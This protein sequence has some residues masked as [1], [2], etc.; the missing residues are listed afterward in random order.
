MKLNPG[1]QIFLSLVTRNQLW[2]KCPQVNV[3]LIAHMNNLF[4]TMAVIH[5]GANS[6]VFRDFSGK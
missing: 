4:L 6:Q 3:C 5:S 1:G 2:I